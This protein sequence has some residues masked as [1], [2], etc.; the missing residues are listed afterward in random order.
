M[1]LT[2]YNIRVYG[3]CFNRQGHILLTDERRGGYL[4]TKFPGG[5]HELGE[6]LGDC[7]KREFM[8][9]LFVEVKVGELFYVNDFL[10]VSAFNPVDQILSVYY[11]VQVLE[12]IRLG[13]ASTRY[14]FPSKAGDAQT[15]RWAD[16]FLL[17]EKDLS[18]P[19]DKVVLQRLKSAL[20]SR[21]HWV[22]ELKS[23]VLD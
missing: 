16:P 22:G 9:E 4:M 18:F 19:I 11:F 6:G 23:E 1:A 7:L 8:E 15:F 2:N 17:E 13:F 5:G 3:L 14:D 10:Q 20:N 21:P 12:P